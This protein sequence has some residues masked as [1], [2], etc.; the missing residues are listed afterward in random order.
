M[1]HVIAVITAK[2]GMREKILEAARAN[3]PAVKAEDGC[4]EY[5]LTV[6]AEGMGSFQTKFGADTFVFDSAPGAGNVDT[7]ADFVPGTDHLS[8][9]N[10]IFGG[11]GAAGA[12]ASGAFHAGTAAQDA[13][14]RIVYDTTTGAL[15]YDADG[16]GGQAAVEVALLA[17]H[18]ALTAA[19]IDIS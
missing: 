4:I 14:D 11:L 19:D 17:G 18:P 3:V 5:S 6:D 7:I 2:P 13:D 16:Q 15:Y 8:L 12:L 10:A 1:I 9:E